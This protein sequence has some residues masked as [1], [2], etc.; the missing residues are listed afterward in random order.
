MSQ[1]KNKTHLAWGADSLCEQKFPKPLV[2]DSPR[3][4]TCCSCVRAARRKLRTTHRSVVPP[5][6]FVP[7]HARAIAILGGVRARPT[8]QETPR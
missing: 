8:E 7:T 5:V 2:S 6:D 4:V 1:R 3:A